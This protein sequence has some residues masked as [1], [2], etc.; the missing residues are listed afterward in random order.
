MRVVLGGLVAL[1]V[2]CGSGGKDGDEAR[3]ESRTVTGTVTDVFG[4]PVPGATVAVEGGPSATTG[5]DGSYE[6]SVQAQPREVGV[7]VAKA[8]FTEQTA[9]T[10]GD[11]IDPV[12]LYPVPE[13]T[14]VYRLLEDG[15]EPVPVQDLPAGSA[16]GIYVLG[17]AEYHGVSG[18]QVAFALVGFQP[19]HLRQVIDGDAISFG[20]GISL[21]PIE[22][23]HSITGGGELLIQRY[24]VPAQPGLR[25]ALAR[26][27]VPPDAGGAIVVENDRGALI[28]VE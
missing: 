11:A 18:G 8:G 20:P 24:S 22:E 13:G 27:A 3:P 4:D 6:L 2:A 26:F 17:E 9:S 16:P 19:T 12:T 7:T 1:L 21:S 15:Y 25:F 14:G 23:K 10:F 28:T 5:D